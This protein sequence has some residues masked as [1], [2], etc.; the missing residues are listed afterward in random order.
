MGAVYLTLVSD[1]I[2]S[3]A[4]LPSCLDVQDRR[5][6]ELHPGFWVLQVADEDAPAGLQAQHVELTF[7]KAEGEPVRVRDRRV[8][9]YAGLRL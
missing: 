5:L 4:E 9:T 7:E 3:H 1:E 2:L 6:S 8:T